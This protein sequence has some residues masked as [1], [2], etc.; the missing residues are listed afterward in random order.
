MGLDLND[1]V[2][3][4]GGGGDALVQQGMHE[5][6]VCPVLEQAAYQIWQQFLMPADGGIAAHD[7]L[8][9]APHLGCGIVKRL[10]HAVQALELHLH[11]GTIGHVV[12]G[13]Q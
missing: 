9:R 13:G 5:G 3:G 8:L 11:P 12:D 1:G 7:D 2:G 10:A 6:G 4:D